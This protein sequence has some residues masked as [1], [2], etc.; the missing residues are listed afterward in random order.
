MEITKKFIEENKGKRFTIKFEN[1][2]ELKNIKLFVST[3]GNIAYLSGRFKRRGLSFPIYDTITGIKEIKKKEHT[4]VGNAKTILKKIHPNAWDDLKVEMKNVIDGVEINQD[5][6]WHFKGKLNLKNITQYLRTGEKERLKNAFDNREDYR[7][8]R[9]TNHHR[10][11]DLSISCETGSDGKFR[12]Y[13]SSEYMGC[14]NGDY[15]LLLNPTTAIFYET[16]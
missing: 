3:C 15:W 2:L 8:C 5:F 1:G 10:G 14:G 13:F 7:W 4:Y 6:E 16:D 11:R 9:T 12:A